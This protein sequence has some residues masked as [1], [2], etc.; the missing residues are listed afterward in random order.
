MARISTI[1]LGLIV[2]CAMIFAFGAQINDMQQNY[3]VSID[4]AYA[5]TYQK[6][7]DT[8]SLAVAIQGNLTGQAIQTT[9]FVETI[10]TGAYKLLRLVM[11][12]ILI[13]NDVVQN[14]VSVSGETIGLPKWIGQ[15]VMLM[16]VVTIV[17][18]IIA[19]VLRDFSRSV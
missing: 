10:G 1:F 11:S 18:L 7:N 19:A 3:N 12:L 8:S 15:I 16:F 5:Q 9:G 14:T 4:P 13:A 2:F 17:F 6:I